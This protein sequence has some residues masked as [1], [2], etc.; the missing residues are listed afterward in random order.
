L[1]EDDKLSVFQIQEKLHL[2]KGQYFRRR[3]NLKL[4]GIAENH[5]SMTVPVN[6]KIDFYTYYFKTGGFNYKKKFF[7]KL[8]HSEFN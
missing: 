6:P 2:T 5:V 8:T 3:K 7:F 1:M 4:L